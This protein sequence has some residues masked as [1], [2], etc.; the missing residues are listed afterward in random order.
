MNFPKPIFRSSFKADIRYNQFSGFIANY[1]RDNIAGTFAYHVASDGRNPKTAQVRQRWENRDRNSLWWFVFCS[2]EHYPKAVFRVHQKRRLRQAFKNALKEKGWDEEGRPITSAAKLER[3]IKGSVHLAVNPGLST[4]KFDDLQNQCSALID[5]LV[6]RQ[7]KW[8]R[9]I[10][11][12]PN[13]RIKGLR[14]SKG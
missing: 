7:P 3:T 5:L 13:N 2:N 14:S 1:Y 6:Q 10:N 9:T 8:A 11:P 4:V 12:T